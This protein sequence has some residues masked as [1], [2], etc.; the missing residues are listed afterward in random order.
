VREAILL[1]PQLLANGRLE[2]AAKAC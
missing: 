1:P 2:S